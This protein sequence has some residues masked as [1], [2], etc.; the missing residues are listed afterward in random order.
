MLTTPRYSRVGERRIYRKIKTQIF[1]RLIN[2]H[3][4]RDTMGDLPHLLS[5]QNIK[6]TQNQPPFQKMKREKN[7]HL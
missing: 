7:S 3:Q 5:S 1:K 6:E 4:K 2:N